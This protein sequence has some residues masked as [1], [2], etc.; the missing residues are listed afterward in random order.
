LARTIL[1]VDDDP[2]FLSA[3]SSLL[4]QTGYEIRTAMSGGEAL[5]FLDSGV[6][7]DGVIID[8]VMPV[9]GGLS[10]IGRIA[11]IQKLPVPIIAVSGAYNVDTDLEVAEYLG[12]KVS[13]RKPQ[14][15]NPLTP[16]LDALMTIVPPQSEERQAVIA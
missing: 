11:K 9:L 6:F 5:A 14:R 1:I 7:I 10:L 13:L 3:L 12:A 16:I 2:E 15:G 8:L 4:A